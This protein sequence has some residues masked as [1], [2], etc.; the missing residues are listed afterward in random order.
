M[1][2]AIPIPQ[3][4]SSP[5]YFHILYLLLIFITACSVFKERGFTQA[6]SLQKQ[7]TKR[8]AKTNESMRVDAVRIYNHEDSTD[9]QSLTEIFPHG[10]F[11]YSTEKGFSGNAKRVVIN[12]RAKAG[13]RMQDSVKL[14]QS[15]SATSNLHENESLLTQTRMKE[16]VIDTSNFNLW[17]SVG[18]L[19]IFAGVYL[20]RN[21]LQE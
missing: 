2:I 3:A 1:K 14:K 13:M 9:K 12:E 5:L 10:F 17:Y 21:R 19:L 11:N 4:P 18:L 8:E 16:K 6:D 15:K 7:S 20:F